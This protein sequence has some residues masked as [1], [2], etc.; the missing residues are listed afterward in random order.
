MDPVA[1]LI[2]LLKNEEGTV[3]NVRFC[4]PNGHSL[5]SAQVASEAVNALSMHQ[6]RLTQASAQ[7]L[8]PSLD[9]RGLKHLFQP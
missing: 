6:N 5:S 9:G 4:V 8:E 3:Q 7:Y 2:G 1:E